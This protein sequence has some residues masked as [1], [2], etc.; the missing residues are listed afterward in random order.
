MNNMKKN[1][2]DSYISAQAGDRIILDD[3]EWKVAEII[4]DTVVLYRESISGKSQTI[5][6]PVEVIKS[7][8]QEQKN[9]D[10]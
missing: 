3:Q 7:H 8:L 5:Q 9:Q 2:S 6:E 10:I 1:Y 4:S